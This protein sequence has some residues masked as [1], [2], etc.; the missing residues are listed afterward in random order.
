[1][2]AFAF[3]P[4][5][6]GSRGFPQDSSWCGSVRLGAPSSPPGDTVT[7]SVAAA[8]AAII[9]VGLAHSL[10]IPAV[11]GWAAIQ[12]F[13]TGRALYRARR[14]VVRLPEQDGVR[15]A[16]TPDQVQD[17]T[18]MV[19]DRDEWSITVPHYEGAVAGFATGLWA[20]EW[21]LRG[22]QAIAALGRILPHV[23]GA[24]ASPDRVDTALT[25]LDTGRSVPALIGMARRVRSP[26][27]LSAENIGYAIASVLMSR[28]RTRPRGRAVIDPGAAG[29]PVRKAW[30]F[31][32]LPPALLLALEML[33]HEDTERAALAGEL[34]LL[35]REWKAAEEL[36]KIADGLAVSDEVNQEIK[37]RAGRGRAR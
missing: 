13:Q 35:E 22:D 33:A 29:E 23:N 12:A 1:M 24:G 10:I 11:G 9:G 14:A 26:T 30:R 18:I 19:R 17:V 4:T 31:S 20:N 21:E 36:A 7:S 28:R 15:A 8:G 3:P 27:S 6:S 34:K 16:M 5:T 37:R 25:L 2:P 32:Y